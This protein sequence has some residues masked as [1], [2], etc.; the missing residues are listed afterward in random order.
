MW[1][2][3]AAAAARESGTVGARLF[4][5]LLF[6]RKSHKHVIELSL[7]LFVFTHLL[8]SIK[9]KP[10][11][12]H[13]KYLPLLLDGAP[14]VR[15][16]CLCI[17]LVWR[18]GQSDITAPQSVTGSR[19]TWI[20]LPPIPPTSPTHTHT[21]TLFIPPHPKAL[22]SLLPVTQAMNCDRS[23]PS[24]FIC[25]LFFFFFYTNVLLESSRF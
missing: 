10:E 8:H 14:Y 11:T 12:I 16:K 6:Q 22:V 3:T 19:E 9:E 24:P 15:H 1:H 18:A 13:L 4:L 7:V 20:I 5:I 21:H 25:N 2:Q 17:V 23:P